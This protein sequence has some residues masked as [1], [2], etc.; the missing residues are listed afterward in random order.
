MQDT[1]PLCFPVLCLQFLQGFDSSLVITFYQDAHF[2]G[3]SALYLYTSFQLLMF[4]GQH[5]SQTGNGL[6]LA[7]RP[8]SS[9]QEG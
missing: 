4:K 7:P 1:S 8:G 9:Q 5:F 3:L 6:L 2:P